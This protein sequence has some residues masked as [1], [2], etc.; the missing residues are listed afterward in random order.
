MYKSKLARVVKLEQIKAVPPS[1]PSH[2]NDSFESTDE[3]IADVSGEELTKLFVIKDYRGAL[4]YGDL[5]V[6]CGEFI[7]MIYESKDYYLAENESAEQGFV[8]KDCCVNLEEA[9]TKARVKMLDGKMCRVT[10]L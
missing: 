8:P 7:Y 9:V 4:V 1:P 5:A 10:S 3:A 6:E 2:T